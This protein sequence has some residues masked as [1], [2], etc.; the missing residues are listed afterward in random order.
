MTPCTGR[1]LAVLPDC[2]PA[3]A[4][5]GRLLPRACHQ[6]T[7]ASGRPWLIGCWPVGSGMRVVARGRDT[8]AVSGPCTA[9]LS[10]LT[11]GHELDR[12]LDGAAGSFHAAGPASGA[13]TGVAAGVV[14]AEG[15]TPAAAGA[16]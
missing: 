5:A 9:D 16:A 2:D 7:H 1:W 11:A 3:S 4:A 13:A 14:G 8:V 12:L 10:R 6:V 15:W